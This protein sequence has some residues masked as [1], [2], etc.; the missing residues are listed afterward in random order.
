MD[1][2]DKHGISYET[3]DVTDDAKAMR[4]MVVLS[5]QRRAP[6]I[7]AD[8]QVLADFGAEELEEWWQENGFAKMKRET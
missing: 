4:E 1:W 8:G 6:V 5:G 2:L 3:L 7:E